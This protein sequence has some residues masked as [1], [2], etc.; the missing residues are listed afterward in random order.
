MDDNLGMAS[1]YLH[2]ANG[3]STT[4]TIDAAGI[5]GIL[6]IWADPLHDGP[7]PGGMS[8]AELVDVRARFLGDPLAPADA[9][10][11]IREWRAVMLRDQ[12]YDEL[13]LWYEYDLFDQLNLMQ[14]LTWI[15]DHGVAGRT[16]VTLICAGSFPG[17]PRF[18]GLGELTAEELAPLFDTREPI[19][20]AQFAVARRGWEA[21]RAPEPT[22]LDAFRRSET[23]A[24][25]FLAPALT[26]FLEDYPWTHDG[27]TRSERTLLRQVAAAPLGVHAAWRRMSDVG[28]TYH[29]TDGSFGELLDV[30]S[31]GDAPLITLTR[32][33]AEPGALAD[34]MIA[35]T[36]AGR[37]VLDGGADWTAMR[38]V[39]RWRGGVHLR[40][41]G[42]TWRWSGEDGRIVRMS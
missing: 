38:S 31:T 17:R 23:S 25:P 36:A 40:P 33:S 19:T 2:V 4:K 42:P 7:V 6:S 41:D 20:S 34:G 28:E 37:T 22:A 14:L 13:V 12:T 18:K 39:E 11:D 29:I 21:F 15:D 27:L 1:R 24:M 16:A 10:N 35:L 8:D 3:T 30:L 32:T 9:V 26:R 5:P